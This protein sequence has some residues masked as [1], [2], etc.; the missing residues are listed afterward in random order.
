MSP[1]PFMLI[2]TL[3]SATLITASLGE[4]R[5]DTNT[6]SAPISPLAPSTRPNS[7]A[8]AAP[9]SY[10]EI[11]RRYD[12][13][14]DGKIDEAE[15]TAAR[16]AAREQMATTRSQRF[17]EF[18]SR[19]DKNGDGKL[20]DSEKASLK[21]FL[22]EHPNQQNNRLREVVMNRLNQPGEIKVQDF[23]RRAAGAATVSKSDAVASP[24][25]KPAPPA[26]AAATKK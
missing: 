14:G 6:V 15:K 5:A 18:L 2:T 4:L 10:E 21:A 20:D 13:N 1:K 12:K 24:P 9:M 7:A 8:T 19:F 3:A 22:S 11:L 26:K 25:P 17:G 23:S 16:A